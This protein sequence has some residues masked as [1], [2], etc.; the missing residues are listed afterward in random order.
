MADQDITIRF[1]G[2]KA[3]AQAE[4]KKLHDEIKRLDKEELTDAQ[5]NE[6]AKAS[7]I[8]EG[9]QERIKAAK[10]SMAHE[11]EG[12]EA[13]KANLGTVTGM[14]GTMSG[15]LL[16]IGSAAAVMSTIQDHFENIRRDAMESAQATYKF[17]ENL[18]ELAALKGRLGDTSE[19]APEMVKF[20]AQTLQSQSDATQFQLS[21]R[22][23]VESA[24]G[25]DPSKGKGI[26]DKK[27]AERIGI[28][29]GKLQSV[30]GGDAKAYGRLGG[31]IPAI[32]RAQGD[33]D[34]TSEEAIDEAGALYA[35]AQ[36][37]AFEF[38]SG[39]N[40][41]G[42]I[43]GLVQTGI[44]PGRQAM[45]TMSAFG[46]AEPESAAT[47]TQQLVRATIGAT[48][49]NR[50]VSAPEGTNTVGT[51][52]YLKS[53]GV[54]IK[55]DDHIAIAR[56]VQEDL[57][58][59][60]FSS[61]REKITYLQSKG[62]GN[63]EDLTALITMG[64]ILES[65]IWDD[66]FQSMLDN[67]E[68]GKG[69]EARLEGAMATDKTFTTRRGM[70]GG[71]LAELGRGAQSESLEAVKR[72]VFAA[73]Q[74]PGRAMH[75]AMKYEEVDAMRPWSSP[76]EFMFGHHANLMSETQQYLEKEGARVGVPRSSLTGDPAY[77]TEFQEWATKIQ[78]AGGGTG[79]E[80]LERIA[81]AS[82]ASLRLTATQ[83]LQGNPTPNNATPVAVSW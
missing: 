65:G 37:A 31:M 82:E 35:L 36:P 26:I 16:G 75:G 43:Q 67:P 76:T 59:Q 34:V 49:R 41:F 22:G 42:N 39:M 3:Q 30:E 2:N 12:F 74:A 29:M 66:K 69:T 68:L 17:R 54:D 5:V 52:E 32:L 33:K 60:N 1:V 8:R 61:E 44:M 70:I 9:N 19:E 81:N 38:S 25:D 56:K 20:R 64:G 57:K 72:N 79:A 83:P 63:Q 18:L 55:K 45:A 46:I 73:Q 40:Q 15:A 62:Y 53:L 71:E 50:K 7:L 23:A 21:Y 80:L 11:S 47:R 77:G 58:N 4:R 14:I 28:G 10:E 27:T 48:G 6:R 13:M 51:A 24:I 78:A